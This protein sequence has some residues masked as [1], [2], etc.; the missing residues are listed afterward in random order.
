MRSR[1]RERIP[2]R[3]RLVSRKREPAVVPEL[4]PV[5]SETR[6]PDSRLGV[7]T[8]PEGW[9]SRAASV[10]STP[11]RSVHGASSP[12][13]DF[14]SGS[15]VGSNGPSRGSRNSRL[16]RTR[17]LHLVGMQSAHAQHLVHQAAHKK[18]RVRFVLRH[19]VEEGPRAALFKFKSATAG[20]PRMARNAG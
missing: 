3:F 4:D 5:C 2:P 9:P 16:S 14:V 1:A 15:N 10:N 17:P 8:W 18:V 13:D 19:L 12:R 20:A 6:R 11:Y 7:G